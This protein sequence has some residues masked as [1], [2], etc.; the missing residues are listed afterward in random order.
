MAFLHSLPA[1]PSLEINDS[2]VAEKWSEWK[3]MWEHCS[4]ASKVNKEERDVQVAAL[5][6]AIGPEARKSSKLGIS[7]LPRRK[8]LKVSSSDSTT[9][10]T[11]EKM[12]PSSGIVLIQD[13]KSLVKHVTAMSLCFV[14]SLISVPLIPLLLMTF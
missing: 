13:S 7:Q 2:N 12:F 9:S 3:E 8:I 11:R 4:V 5:L 14:K 6:T 10:A 1:P